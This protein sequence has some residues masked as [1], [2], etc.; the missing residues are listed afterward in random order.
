V[1]YRTSPEPSSKWKRAPVLVSRGHGPVGRAKLT[2]ERMMFDTRRSS[3][4][5]RN[6]GP[7]LY[8]SAPITRKESR[9][10]VGRAESG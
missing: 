4:Q 6:P 8:L 3:I 1:S 5:P 2:L 9:G 7:A 10:S